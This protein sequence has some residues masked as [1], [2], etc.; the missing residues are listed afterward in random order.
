MKIIYVILLRKLNILWL[1]NKYVKVFRKIL[2]G[3]FVLD[4]VSMGIFVVFYYRMDFRYYF[5]NLY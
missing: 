3:N 4:L 1:R 2:I 5:F